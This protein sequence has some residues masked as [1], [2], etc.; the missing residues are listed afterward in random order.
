MQ[1]LAMVLIVLMN[2]ATVFCAPV[3]ARTWTDKTG[4]LTVEAELLEV[5][6]GKAFLRKADG[7]VIGI[8]IPNLSAGDLNYLKSL[9][10]SKAARDR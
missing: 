3:S 5:K 6:D 9:G 1:R 4:R 2:L 8:A 10:T 7:Q